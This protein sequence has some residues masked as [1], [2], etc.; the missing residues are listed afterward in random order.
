MAAPAA[1]ARTAG[2]TRALRG[3]GA[4]AA[5]D[6]YSARPR[7]VQF[8][9]RAPLRASSVSKS[10]SALMST[11]CCA[12]ASSI[13]T[14][15]GCARVLDHRSCVGH[16]GGVRSRD[17]VPQLRAPAGRNTPPGPGRHP[18]GQHHVLGLDVTVL[19]DHSGLRAGLHLRTRVCSKISPPCCC[20]SAAMASS[21]SIGSSCAC[22]SRRI[23]SKTGKGSSAAVSLRRSSPACSPASSSA[24]TER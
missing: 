2:A 19:G 16:G 7:A 10:V 6:P 11:R 23:A 24:R 4:R 22:S 17:R 12:R 3:C 14:L 13:T 21:T 18:R 8:G 1:V 20:R 5:V 15:S 9:G